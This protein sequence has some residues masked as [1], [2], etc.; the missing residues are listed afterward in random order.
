[1]MKGRLCAVP[2]FCVYGGMLVDILAQTDAFFAGKPQQWK[3]FEA[4]RKAI[5]VRYPDASIRVMKTCIAFDDP[6]PLCYVS[7]PP[8]KG[9]AGLMLT[10]SLKEMMHHS[11]FCM[12]VPVSKQR[13]TVH[14]HIA[15][16][17]QADQELMDL[18][19]LS[20]R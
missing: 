5:L 15:D 9:M 10:I 7:V 17:S 20:H 13:F 1:M 2:V 18:I 14:I 12:V 16:E 4:V 19:A 8:K 3:V 6:K 11:R